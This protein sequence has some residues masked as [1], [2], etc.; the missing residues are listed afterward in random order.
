MGT[1]RRCCSL[2]PCKAGA[3]ASSRVLCLFRVWNGVVLQ[4]YF[5]KGTHPL[6]IVLRCARGRLRVP[7]V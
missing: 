2:L 6:G 5:F 1:S 3:A 7:L 4:D